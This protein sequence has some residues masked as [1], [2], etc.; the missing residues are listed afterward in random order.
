MPCYRVEV[1]ALLDEDWRL[2]F[3]G[4]EV[5]Q[6]ADGNS[7][8]TGNVRDQTELHGLLAR[9]RDLNLKLISVT[10]EAND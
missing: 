3:E 5:M 2:W 8:L 6:I 7:V 10:L 4:W 1:A 9:L